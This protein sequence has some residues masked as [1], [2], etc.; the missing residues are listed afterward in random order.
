MWHIA[1]ALPPEEVVQ[2]I[3]ACF[4]DLVIGGGNWNG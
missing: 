2:I 4:H 3:N 1:S